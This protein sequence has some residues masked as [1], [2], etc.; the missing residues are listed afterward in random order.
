MLAAFWGPEPGWAAALD[1]VM[2][3]GRA[4]SEETRHPFSML[5]EL[6]VANVSISERLPLKV[7]DFLYSEC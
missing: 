7:P 2:E 6:V 4:R 3:E 1:T 5:D